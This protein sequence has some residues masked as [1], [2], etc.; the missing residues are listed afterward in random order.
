MVADC[1]LA[2]PGQRRRLVGQG[3]ASVHVG[4]L[5]AGGDLGD[6]V[7]LDPAEVAALDFLGEELRHKM[8]H[9]PIIT[10]SSAK[11]MTTS[12]VAELRMVSVTTAPLL[13]RHHAPAAD[14]GQLAQPLVEPTRPP[15][16][17]PLASAGGDGTEVTSST[18]MLTAAPLGDILV[19][20]CGSCA[21]PS[22]RSRRPSNFADGSTW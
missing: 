20:R 6:G 12:L 14:E 15:T 16:V 13:E 10:D 3:R 22:A 5:G 17:P 19:G 21:L 8:I 1:T 9:S 7:G 2:T 11:P 18:G 4:H